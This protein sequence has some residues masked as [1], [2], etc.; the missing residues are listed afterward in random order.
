MPKPKL[1]SVD[2]LLFTTQEERDDL[3]REKVVDIPIAE[4]DDFP[5]HPFEVRIDDEM[6]ALVENIKER[7]VVTP[8]LA[9]Q[10][11]D[12]RYELISGH[13]RKLA[14]ELA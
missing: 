4:I 9:R 13:R 3:Q 10:K 7:G 2:E 11:E 1:A 6:R 14:S 5:D 8:A 12:G